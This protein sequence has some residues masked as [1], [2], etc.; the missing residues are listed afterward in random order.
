MAKEHA[1]EFEKIIREGRE[2]KRNQDLAARIFS[3]GNANKRRASAPLGQT[4]GSLASRVGVQKRVSSVARL[5]RGNV[6]GEWTHDLHDSHGSKPRK[7]QPDPNSLAARIHKP[8]TTIPKPRPVPQNARPNRAA[9]L[10]NA[11]NR[12]TSSPSNVQQMQVRPP[13][14]AQGM[15]IKGL[16]GPFAVMA[17]NFA[18][19]TTAADIESA[20][21]PVGG[22]VTSCRVVKS[23]PIVIAEIVFENK[24]GADR[25]IQTFNNQNADG[26]TLH[27]YLK[28]SGNYSP[29]PPT[30]PRAQRHNSSNETSLGGNSVVVDGSM[31]FNDMEVDNARDDGYSDGGLYSDSMVPRGPANGNSNER[32][33]R[34]RGFRSG[35]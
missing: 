1:T 2:R 3:K 11:F 29:Q 31:G 34:G 28:P 27:V 9:K 6:N 33:R 25:V 26:R 23:Y 22:L 32:S 12:S 18:P 16:A 4:G 10:A 14:A 19:G 13:P 21:T 24:E 35:R 8:G 30:G 7:P 17:Q 20:M 15:M 5:P